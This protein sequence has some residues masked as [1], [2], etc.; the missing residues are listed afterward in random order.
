MKSYE[1]LAPVLV[2]GLHGENGTR[3]YAL[4]QGDVVELPEEHVAVRAMLARKQIREVEAARP[5]KSKK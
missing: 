5:P 4:K 1:V 2:F 3:D